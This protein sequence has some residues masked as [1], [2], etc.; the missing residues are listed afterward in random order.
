[1][2]QIIVN[3]DKAESL[4]TPRDMTN[5]EDLCYEIEKAYYRSADTSGFFNEASA[6][7]SEYFSKNRSQYQD[8]R[9]RIRSLQEGKPEDV[10]LFLEVISQ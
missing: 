1:M 2:Y 8:F 3:P 5:L 9:K 7:A 6:I 4:D 10:V